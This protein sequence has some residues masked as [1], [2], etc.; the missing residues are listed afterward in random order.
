LSKLYIRL[1]EVSGGRSFPK[2]RT[3]RHGNLDAASI[4]N[5]TSSVGAVTSIEAPGIVALI[6]MELIISAT[7]LAEM[8]M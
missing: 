6:A 7:L 4:R 5:L 2:E 8:I 1:R 3:P